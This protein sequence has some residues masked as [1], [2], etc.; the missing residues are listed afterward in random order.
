MAKTSEAKEQD[1]NF[2]DLFPKPVNK[3]KQALMYDRAL[4]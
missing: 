1:V 4:K 2:D 3:R